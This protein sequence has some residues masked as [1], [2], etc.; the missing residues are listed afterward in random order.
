MTLVEFED[1]KQ[2]TVLVNADHVAY[3][4]EEGGRVVIALGDGAKVTLPVPEG[5]TPRA[6]VTEAT[7]RLEAGGF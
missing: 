3:V 7:R 2:E 5:T 1:Y 6:V 4:A